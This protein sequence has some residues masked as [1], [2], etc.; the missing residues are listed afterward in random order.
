MQAVLCGWDSLAGLDSSAQ[1]SVF[2]CYQWRSWPEQP[3]ANFRSKVSSLKTTAASQED[4]KVISNSGVFHRTSLCCFPLLI[5]AHRS[6]W[7]LLWKITGPWSLPSTEPNRPDHP[8]S[9]VAGCPCSTFALTGNFNTQC[10]RA[11]AGPRRWPSSLGWCFTR[12]PACLDFL[13]AATRRRALVRSYMIS[14]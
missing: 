6:P 12:S 8:S 10:S 13:S 9:Q 14:V 2:Y 4:L 11:K 3:S 5:C 1:A 7:Q